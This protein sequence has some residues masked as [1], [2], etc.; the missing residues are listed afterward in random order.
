MNNGDDNYQGQAPR[1][2][3]KEL[4]APLFQHDIPDILNDTDSED[5]CTVI[6]GNNNIDINTDIDTDQ[7]HDSVNKA[8]KASI[9]A[10]SET[11]RRRRY[12]S[13][14]SRDRKVQRNISTIG[15]QV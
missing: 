12:R 6:P 8:A 13:R 10:E 9:E 2:N 3:N 11:F 7:V 5:E 1:D 15:T 4:L 14:R